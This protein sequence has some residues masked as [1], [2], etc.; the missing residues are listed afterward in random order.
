MVAG[1]AVGV[2]AGRVDAGELDR[3]VPLLPAKAV[4]LAVVGGEPGVSRIACID[5][6]GRAVDDDRQILTPRV[7]GADLGSLA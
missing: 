1:D 5:E 2:E 6:R 7:T 3:E 4:D